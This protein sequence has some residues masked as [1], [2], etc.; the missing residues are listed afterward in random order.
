MN[1]M[2]PLV[3]KRPNSMLPGES[4]CF[5]IAFVWTDPRHT[6]WSP[7]IF[8]LKHL[9]LPF[10]LNSCKKKLQGKK[11]SGSFSLLSSKAGTWQELSVRFPKMS[12]RIQDKTGWTWHSEEQKKMNARRK[13]YKAPRRNPLR[14]RKDSTFGL[15]QSSAAYLTRSLI[16]P[17]DA[18]RQT[19]PCWLPNLQPKSKDYSSRLTLGWSL[20]PV[21][22]S[23]RLQERSRSWYWLLGH[24]NVARGTSSGQ[25]SGQWW[26]GEWARPG[27][28]P[29]EISFLKTK[30]ERNEL[31][32][33][34]LL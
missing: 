1:S 30:R 4:I 20:W 23:S 13:R 17:W 28:P 22:T 8:F 29:F 12:T 2:V 25:R 6:F 16:Q 18:C 9:Q 31:L 19:D 32:R 11:T 26:A 5:I 27:L 3:V 21:A 34:T 7:Y 14:C 10:L 15:G 24:S 33:T